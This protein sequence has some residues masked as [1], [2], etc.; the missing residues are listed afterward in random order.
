M[1]RQ[2]LI[3]RQ[4]GR[5]A[6]KHEDK[7]FYGKTPAEALKK[8]GANIDQY[9][10]DPSVGFE[11]FAV[12]VHRVISGEE[13]GSFFLFD[14]LSELQRYWFSDLMVCNFFCLTANF[15]SERGG[16]VK[17]SFSTQTTCCFAN[18]SICFW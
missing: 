16:V 1:P 6:C 7:Y 18:K 14:C 12:Q 10:L 5:Y 3:A 8:R 15:L 2:K 17:I 11:T 13:L 9:T 4:D